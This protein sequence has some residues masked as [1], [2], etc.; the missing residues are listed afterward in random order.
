MSV[1]PSPDA[2]TVTEN[3]KEVEVNK[4]DDGTGSLDLTI[5]TTSSNTVNSADSSS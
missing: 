4:N 1:I 2:V 5:Q 3:G